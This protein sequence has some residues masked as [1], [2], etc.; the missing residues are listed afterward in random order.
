MEE[1]TTFRK[2][3]KGLLELLRGYPD[4]RFF[5]KIEFYLKNR[6]SSIKV[7][8]YDGIIELAPEEEE[9]MLNKKLTPEQILLLKKEGKEKP[10]CWYRLTSKGVDLAI[11]MINL[12]SGEKVL[13]YAQETKYFSR[14]LIWLTYL[15]IFLTLGL[16]ILGVL[17]NIISLWF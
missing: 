7:L 8:N 15:I 17:Q 16:L 10:D 9:K 1:E 6:E 3:K 13:K 14:V 4:Y 2:L 11:S 5:G 12:D